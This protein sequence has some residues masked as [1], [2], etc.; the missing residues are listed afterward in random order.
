MDARDLLVTGTI[1]TLDPARPRAEALLA[2][3]GHILTLGSVA[4]CRR[5]AGPGAR[6]LD[7]GG[8]CVIPGLADAHGHVVLHALALEEV[9]LK[10]ARDERE[11][12]RRA[13]ERARTLEPGAW[14]RGR[15][16][17]QNRWAGSEMPT[18]R[19][20][21]AAVPDRPVLL[22]RVDGHAAWV[23][24]RALELAGIS[25]ASDDPPGGR[26]VRDERGRPTG[27]LIDAAQDLVRARIS[28]PTGRELERLILSGLADLARYGLTSVHDA[29]CTSSVLGEYARLAAADRL[30]LRVYAMVDG[31]QPAGSLAAE[32]ARWSASPSIGRLDVRAVKLFADGALGSRGAALLDGYAD[33]PGN[34]GLFLIPPAE[35]RERMGQVARAG[36]QPAVHAIGDAACREVLRTLAAL[37]AQLDL[38][39]LRPRVEHLQLVR[40]EDLPLLRVSG[41]VASMQP[42]HAVADARWVEARVGDGPALRGAYAW[43]QVIGA[44][45]VLALG[46]DFPVESPDPRLGLHAAEARWP[47]EAAEPWRPEERLTRAEALRG[48]THGPAYASFAEGKRGVLREGADA[49]LTLFGE[50]LLAVPVA[51][52]AEIPLLATVVGGRVEHGG[53]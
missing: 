5:A 12:A 11:C 9:S 37:A 33:E 16:W 4:E 32:L 23:N 15:G 45:G 31:G 19:A 47:A 7:A 43:R 36:F 10:G 53:A 24:A 39:R 34:R 20:L 14:V 13:A 48:F 21:S 28:G 46:S 8:G 17:D 50:D 1:H 3:D 29:G 25:S 38:A 30:P 52:L 26:I 35:L 2:R 51:R 6:R 40:A 41:A 18:E 42:V 22:E 27:V 44:G 49:D